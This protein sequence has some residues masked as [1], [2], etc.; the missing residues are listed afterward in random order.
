LTLPP[1]YPI[2][3]TESLARKQCAPEAAAARWL[4]AGA[5]ILQLRHKGHWPRALFDEARRIAQMC[6][7]HD[8]LFIVDDRADFARLLGAGLHVG[9]DDLSPADARR[10]IGPDAVLGFSSHNAEQL[11]AAD[12]AP[13]D[14]VAFGPVFATRSKLNPDPVVG[15]AE[16]RRA[17]ALAAKPLVAI[18]GITRANAGSV[19][20]AGADS[21]AVIGDMLPETCTAECLRA[22]MEEWLQLPNKPARD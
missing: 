6:R 8:A 13:V 3:D 16:L 1:I 12:A 19:F 17:R 11:C 5:R 20:A 7:E 14:Y 22:R 15:L 2:L 10:I 21:V 4:D 18:G 9:Q